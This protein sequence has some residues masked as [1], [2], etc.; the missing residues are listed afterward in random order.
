MA[1]KARH[2]YKKQTECNRSF[3]TKL[4]V[5][6]NKSYRDPEKKGEIRKGWILKD[7]YTNNIEGKRNNQLDV[8]NQIK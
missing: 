5:V 4:T 2:A 6:D 1:K 7:G 8:G 3:I